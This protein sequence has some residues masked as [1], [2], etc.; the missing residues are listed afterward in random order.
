VAEVTP[1]SA[2]GYELA[3]VLNESGVRLNKVAIILRH[4]NLNATGIYTT[5][6]CRIWK[7]FNSIWIMNG[8]SSCNHGAI[9]G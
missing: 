8:H 4:R 3:K 6:G 1:L 9:A 5:L 2:G 7:R